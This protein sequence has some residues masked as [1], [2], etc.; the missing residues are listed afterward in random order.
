MSPRNRPIA[1]YALSCAIGV[2]AAGAL[3]TGLGAQ[4]GGDLDDLV[5]TR[6]ALSDAQAQ[7]RAARSRAEALEAQALRATAAADR[8]SQDAA[9]IAARIQQ[10]EAETAA[11]EAQIRLLGEQSERLRANLAARQQPLVRL[12]AALQRLARRP[13]VLALL[14]PGSV[15]DTMHMRALIETM[16][17]EVQRRTAALR[18]EIAKGR[19]LQAQMRQAQGGLRAEETVLAKRRESLASL[20]SQQRLAARDV[21]GSA[22]REAERALALAEQ[23]RDLGSLVTNLGKEDALRGKLADLPGPVMRPSRP[24]DAQVTAD[25]AAAPA[26]SPLPGY[27]LPLQGRLVTG[28]GDDLQGARSRGISIAAQAGAQVVAPAAGRVAFAG[29]Y[30]GFG[31]I[32]IISHDGG[33]T[34][35]VTGMAEVNARVG[36]VLV[37]GSPLGVA[38]PGRPVVTLELRHDAEAVNPL[39]YVRR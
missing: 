21:N 24:E 8:T 31:Q 16:V 23:A 13:L 39:D 4:T 32:V 25:S 26:P 17:P 18:A 36:D 5:A 22:D 37:A 35:L 14:R 6:H 34:S 9:A 7:S 10:A 20:E 33:W 30:R 28:F 29:P 2:V 12:T 15:M 3:S 38:G 19:A 27:M 1:L 11:K